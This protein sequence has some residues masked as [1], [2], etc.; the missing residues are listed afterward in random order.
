MYNMTI[1]SRPDTIDPLKTITTKEIRNVGSA[2]SKG[3][4]LEAE[5]NFGKNLRLF[6]GYTYTDA[7]ITSHIAPTGVDLYG[8]QL[9][10]VPRH[11][12]NAGVD[13]TSGPLSL[14]LSGRYVAKRYNQDDNSDRV[15]NVYGSYDQY[16]VVDMKVA[17]RFTDW[18][19]FSVSV[20]NL[21]DHKYYVYYPSPGR[22]VFANLD[23]K[24]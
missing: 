3:I 2:L 17:H 22:T 23:L 24:F 4:E 5:Q 10:A 7:R 1:D 12:V 11:M 6:A 19:T 13:A 15:S 20:N 8:K 16:F 21:F 9:A 18:S 14:Y